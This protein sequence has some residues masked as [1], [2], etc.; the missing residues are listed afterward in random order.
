MPHCFDFD[1]FQIGSD[2]NHILVR[3]EIGLSCLDA[4]QAPTQNDPGYPPEWDIDEVILYVDG[5]PPLSMSETQFATYF[6][7][8]SD[9]INNAFE[10]AAQN[11]D[12]NELQD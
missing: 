7:G 9:I 4:G 3:V 12:P 10:D 8:A 6:P 11:G 2:E 5:A 1:D